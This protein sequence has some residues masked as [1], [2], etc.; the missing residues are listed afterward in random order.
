MFSIV[1]S[2]VTISDELSI[3]GLLKFDEQ[4]GYYMDKPIAAVV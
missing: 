4:N 2:S 1:T 3:F